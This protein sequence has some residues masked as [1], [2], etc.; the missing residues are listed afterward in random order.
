MNDDVPS[1]TNVPEGMTDDINN[2][3]LILKNNCQLTNEMLKFFNPDIAFKCNNDNSIQET[4]N[5]DNVTNEFINDV[6]QLEYT[7]QPKY[8][9]NGYNFRN[10][11]FNYQ[12]FFIKRTEIPNLTK[13]QPPLQGTVE[14]QKA[15]KIK[16]FNEIYN[17]YHEEIYRHG[18]K[19]SKRSK[20]RP[21][22]KRKST[23]RKRGTR[24]R[25]NKKR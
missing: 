7:F 1:T 6:Q 18:G 20:K 16:Y 9:H 22:R 5:N 19:R 13:T 25:A 11:V 2:Y 17:R 23:K 4:S 15:L 21:N 8:S 10:D 12:C 3:I 14:E 24:K